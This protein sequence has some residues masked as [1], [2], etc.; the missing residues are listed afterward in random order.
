MNEPIR[1][2]EDVKQI[3]ELKTRSA[4]I[5]GQVKR[6]RRPVLLTRRGRGDAEQLEVE[7]NDRHPVRQ[8]NVDAVE[9]GVKAVADGDLHAHEEAL[10]ILD[11]F[12]ER[13]G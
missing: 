8:A 2:S 7:D 9:V 11:T 3:S 5:I 6:T 1:F 13:N 12:G 4:E 10:A